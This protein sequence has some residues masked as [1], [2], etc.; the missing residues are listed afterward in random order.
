MMQQS[1]VLFDIRHFDGTDFGDD[2]LRGSM[3]RAAVSAFT[4]VF[5]SLHSMLLLTR[6]AT[7]RSTIAMKLC[8]GHTVKKLTKEILTVVLPWYTIQGIGSFVDS[9]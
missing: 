1:R 9:E 3:S 8:S 4:L 7:R 2:N 5:A 6:P